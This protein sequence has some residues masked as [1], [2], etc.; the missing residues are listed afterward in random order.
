MN[1]PVPRQ[2]VPDVSEEVENQII[3]EVAQEFADELKAD[4][5][6]A[7]PDYVI[8]PAIKLP[9]RERLQRYMYFIWQ[10][11][12]EDPLGRQEELAFLLNKD[13]LELIK[14]GYAPP[15][16]SRPWAQLVGISFVFR[17]LQ[18]D[19]REL[20]SNFMRSDRGKWLNQEVI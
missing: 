5:K 19:L 3:A 7:Y 13:Y 14:G 20:M 8:A 9:N 15:P 18:A 12:P 2:I 16:L 11:Y 4:I 17:D 1:Q 6:A 10:A